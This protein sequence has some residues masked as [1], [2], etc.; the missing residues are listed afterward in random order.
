V[1]QKVLLVYG[2]AGQGQRPLDG[3][4][5]ITHHQDNFPPTSWQV[6]ETHFKAL[7]YLVPGAN[8][9]R[10]DFSSPKLVGNNS[11][12]PLHTTRF[13]INYLPLT[14]T[15]PLQLAILVGKD[16]P[17]TFDAP[18]EKITKEGNDI[19]TA[20]RKY[21]MAAHLWSAFTAE[22]MFRHG[23]G[24]RSF[25]FEEE[26]QAGTL[27]SRDKETGQMRNEARVHVIRSEKTVAEIRDFEV[28]QQNQ[29]A[30][31]KNDLFGFAI[32]ALKSYF[33]PISG[34]KHYVAVLILDSH[35]DKRANLITGHA[36]LG[37]GHDNIQLGIFGSQ[38]LHTYPSTI[39]EVVPALT[40]CTK[41]N[42]EF[43]AA[44]GGEDSGT[45]WQA[46]CIGKSLRCGTEI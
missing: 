15:P 30:S 34:Q 37:G 26:Y 28:A 7:V 19:D 29:K 14:N 24:R 40:D 20:I 36:A 43:V 5:T 21:R 31:R 17:C 45:W 41:T 25:R 13:R 4:V 39:E 16:S 10:L 2:Q 23:F 27:S 44:D 35:W 18:P 22:Q 46:A 3:T 32:D 8:D 12:V 11:P 42:T 38:A 1:N 6:C 33:K 9:L